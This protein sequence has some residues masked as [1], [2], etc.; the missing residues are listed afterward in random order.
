MDRLYIYIIYASGRFFPGFRESVP[1][2]DTHLCGTTTAA[3][4]VEKLSADRSAA[5]ATT[6]VVVSSARCILHRSASL[7]NP[8]RLFP[9]TL[10]LYLLSTTAVVVVVLYI[11]IRIIIRLKRVSAPAEES[12]APCP[13]TAFFPPAVYNISAAVRVRVYIV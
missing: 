10:H 9:K 2:G 8:A 6:A 1:E 4:G 7:T 12:Y 13:K 5:A 3:G 11:Y